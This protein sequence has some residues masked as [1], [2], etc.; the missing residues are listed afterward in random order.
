MTINEMHIATK[1]GL[2]KTSALDLPSYEPEEIDY[3][4][5]RAINVFIKTRYSG[6]N[7]KNESFEQSQKRID[8]LRTLVTATTLDL[9]AVTSGAIYPEEYRVD[10]Y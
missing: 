7:A 5:N 6:T 10:K 1:L 3:W 8:D 4:L 9:V 2:D